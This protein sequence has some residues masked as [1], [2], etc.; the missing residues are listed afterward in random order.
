MIGEKIR[1][2][3]WDVEQWSNLYHAIFDSS[4]PESVIVVIHRDGVPIKIIQIGKGSRQDLKER[5]KSGYE[6]KDI[7]RTI[8]REEDVDV[9]FAVSY[10]AIRRISSGF[11]STVNIDANYIKQLFSLKDAISSEIGDGIERYPVGPNWFTNL[12]YKTVKRILDAAPDKALV[13]LTIF[14]KDKI[15]TSWIIGIERG[16][17]N[18]ITTLDAIKP[19]RRLITD[20]RRT[21][22][23]IADGVK[24]QFGIKPL[25][26]FMDHT[27]FRDLLS[28][29]E[30]LRFLEDA[31]SNKKIISSALPF[32][33]RVL[34]F[35]QRVFRRIFG[36][37]KD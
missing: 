33:Y 21:Y 16:T 31:L 2:V 18:L 4:N 29:K 32:K 25:A 19:K 13:M 36:R 30:K 3:D 35:L 20:W 37:K 17:I 34:L 10:P 9:V 15:W 27:T 7:I 24:R 11:Q 28:S 8:H 14:S 22:R 23:Q 1:I 26:F 12:K 5:F 6:I